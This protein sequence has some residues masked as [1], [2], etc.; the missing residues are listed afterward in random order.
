MIA[1]K[2]PR[3]PRPG[4]RRA[5]FRTSLARRGCAVRSPQGAARRTRRIVLSVVASLSNRGRL[6][7]QLIRNV[8]QNGSRR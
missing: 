6:P 7:R 2:Q 4:A 8:M 5:A 1:P 3:Q